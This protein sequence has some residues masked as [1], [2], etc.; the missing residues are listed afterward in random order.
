MV[1]LMKDL[2]FVLM[3]DMVLKL[4]FGVVLIDIGCEMVEKFE[5]EGVFECKLLECVD[6]GLC[7]GK[8]VLINVVRLV[9][10]II[11]WG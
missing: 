4:V 6:C 7:L 5:I 9:G 3:I 10:L 1:L 11:K 8:R 2:V